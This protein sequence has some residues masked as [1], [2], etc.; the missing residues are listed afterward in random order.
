MWDAVATTLGLWTAGGGDKAVP[1][2][3]G[4]GDAVGTTGKKKTKRRNKI[5]SST[6]FENY[7]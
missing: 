3:G 6:Y 7:V 2:A 4:N 5:K 1:T